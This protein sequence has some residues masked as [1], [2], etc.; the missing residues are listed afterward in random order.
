MSVGAWFMLILTT[1]FMLTSLLVLFARK[2]VMIITAIGMGSVLLAV[3]FFI[4]GAP[5]AGAIE[6]SVGAGLISVL[7][8]VA[9][10]ITDPT[11]DQAD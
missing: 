7:F 9:T 4:F 11:A 3:M 6:L 5:F 1:G 10:S 2:L 8:I